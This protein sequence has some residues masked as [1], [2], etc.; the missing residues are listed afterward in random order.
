MKISLIVLFLNRNR[1][2][3]RKR[4]ERKTSDGE[5]GKNSENK[6]TTHND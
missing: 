6:K 1:Y 3:L 4:I 5:K 2:D